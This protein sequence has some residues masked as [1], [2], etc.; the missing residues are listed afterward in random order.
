MS[1]YVL[2]VGG[3]GNKILESLVYCAAID[4]FYTVDEEGARSPI[5][6]IRMLSV[7]VDSACGN[8]TRAKRAA[9]YYEDIRQAYEKY[10]A[11]HPGFHT[12]VLAS[13]WN[14]NLSKRAMSVD[15]M[16]EGHRRDKLLSRTIFSRT[17]SSLEYSEGFR[18]HPD[19]GVLFFS[20]VLN[21]L[22]RL[23]AEGQPDE[24]NDLLDRIT[25]EM[26][27]GE[28]V[29]L[30]LC[31]SI[32]G[33]TGAS[34]IP[35]IA[36]FLREYF[37][38][39][40]PLFEMAAMLML[41]YYKV[42]PSSQNEEMEIVVK[43]STFLDKARTALQ[44]Y[45]MEGMIRSGE[46]D[47]KGIFDALYMLGL[48][49]EA[50]ITTR[51]YSTGS[52]SQ[53]NDAHML[54]WLA[55]RCISHFFRTGFR[56]KDAHHIDC[57]YY[58]WHTPQLCWQ[59]FDQEEELYRNG[60]TSLL[61]AAA[62]FFAELYPSLLGCANGHR[63]SCTRIGYCAPFFSTFHKKTSAEQAELENLLQSL[64]HFL[65]F[66]SNW[67]IQVVRT[68]PP[69]MREKRISENLRT[70]AAENYD[71]LVKRRAL[72]TQREE[73]KEESRAWQEE[74]KTLRKE[75]EDMQQTRSQLAKK[76]GGYAWLSVLKDAQDSA[77]EKLYRQ[78]ESI[79]EAE[80]S[81]ERM[82]GEDA[83]LVDA[84]MI[85]QQTERLETMRRAAVT[86]E[87]CREQISLDI[88]AAIRENVVQRAPEQAAQDEDALSRN[89][90]MDAA[91]LEK[92]Y[93][94][95]NQ[96]GLKPA[97]RSSQ[98]FDAAAIELQKG[99]NKMSIQRV[100]DRMDTTR[101]IAGLGGGTLRGSGAEGALC[102][103]LTTLLRAVGEEEGQ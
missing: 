32:F 36:R 50:F 54:E 2:A 14:M 77:R 40:S 95:L 71:Q 63:K 96:Y 24:M 30:I 83:G 88:E 72:L 39:N 97:Q 25:D 38:D 1:C 16:V 46:N 35:A 21:S 60:Y 12:A 93:L 67:M 100:P 73:H 90:L 75:Y 53:E 66:Y 101:V 61:K 31:G 98:V 57:Y 29:K 11:R 27:R 70:E 85:R 82:N 4:G 48:P 65:N 17:E 42:P 45:G 86:M 68:I 89:G 22:E 76:I 9:E 34:G 91:L 87:L 8:T 94:L 81:L 56:G 49:T 44:Y 15:K 103:F 59:S 102:S 41:P 78:E 47:E 6:E 20:D 18:G 64:Y 51:I 58:Q 33:G 99:L 37:R 69:T 23:R 7:D 79:A 43:S 28:K 10:P 62:L 84:Q 3:T 52:Q 80:A 74:T 5:P 13:R 92:L 26:K 19:L 55:T